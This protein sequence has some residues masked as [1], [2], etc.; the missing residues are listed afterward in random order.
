MPQ[1]RLQKRD[2]SVDNLVVPIWLWKKRASLCEK[3]SD[4]VGYR[5][6]T[7]VEDWNSLR[8][9]ADLQS[10]LKLVVQV[11]VSEDQIDRPIRLYDRFGLRKLEAVT[12]SCPASRRTDSVFRRTIASSSTT[13]M[14]ATKGKRGLTLTFPAYDLFF[15]TLK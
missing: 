8:E 13:R 2:Y 6:T 11:D 9:L 15:C 4:R 12:V 7:G 1:P 10:S 5:I 3:R 14:F